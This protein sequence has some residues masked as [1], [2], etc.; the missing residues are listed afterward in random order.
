MIRLSIAVLIFSSHYTFGQRSIEADL[1]S[2][3]KTSINEQKLPLDLISTADS[4]VAYRTGEKYIIIQATTNNGLKS[5][6][7]Q[8]NEKVKYHVWHGED[9][10]LNN[11][12]E[13][14][15]PTSILRKGHGILVKYR[16]V[17]AISRSDK[18]SMKCFDG[19][20]KAKRE[21]EEWVIK[22]CKHRPIKCI[23]WDSIYN[24]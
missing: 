8:S 21:N 1:I 14:L 17:H 10:F 12:N 3:I 9:L 23:D 20:I 7:D 5:F 4:T 11:T 24:D 13:W 15:T 6:Y 19:V 16:I 22:K 18:K 2:I